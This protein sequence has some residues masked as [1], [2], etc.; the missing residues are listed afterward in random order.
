MVKI[1]VYKPEK[2]KLTHLSQSIAITYK[3][4]IFFCFFVFF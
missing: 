4:E 3:K 2:K 1:D